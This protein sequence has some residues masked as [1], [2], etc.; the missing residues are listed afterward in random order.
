MSTFIVLTSSVV[1]AWL[2]IRIGLAIARFY[3]R[4]FQERRAAADEFYE[5]A[6]RI[7]DHP[8]TSPRDLDLID[9]MNEVINYPHAALSLGK[10]LQ[11]MQRNRVYSSPPYHPD[12]EVGQ[13]MLLAYDR[14][15]AAITSRSPYI[16]SVVRVLRAQQ[17]MQPTVE[18]AAK[19]SP[20]HNGKLAHA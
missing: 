11:R 16:G 19:R 17:A 15:I 6:N 14:Y 8:K 18:A 10:A 3:E 13:L 12:P 2:A 9:D 20:R 7:L 1:A 4:R 5:L